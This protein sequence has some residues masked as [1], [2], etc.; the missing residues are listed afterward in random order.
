MLNLGRPA[1]AKT[2]TTTDWRD[3]WTVGY[4]PEL[5]VGVW[6]GNAD[7]SPM[8]QVSGITGAAPI[9]HDVMEA[10]DSPLPISGEG[11]GVR[12]FP[13]PPGLVHVEVCPA[14]G[15][16]PGPRCPHRRVELFI[17]GTEPRETCDVH[18]AVR[19]CTVS[20]QLATDR[21]PAD[22]IEE[23]VYQV[24]PSAAL[25]WAR[26][27]G[28]P[29]PPAAPCPI[30]GGSAGPPG[31]NEGLAV[32][33][34]GPDEGSVFRISPALPRSDQRIALSARVEGAG[35]VAWVEFRVDDV[36]VGRVTV[37]PWRVFWVLEPGAHVVQAVVADGAG[38][39]AISA[40]VRFA[41][42]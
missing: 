26:E 20:G 34:T 39:Q 2:G 28:I 8:I 11:P 31:E 36:P 22:R 27:R 4:T 41:V 19:I 21:C 9:W 24:L 17:A 40:P 1:A 35:P 16:L 15:Q 18:R 14:S 32:V 5:V 6:T 33:V 23:R 10:L 12:A 29:Q 25:D 7:N 42:E 3:N 37:P 38:Q 30:H 13:E